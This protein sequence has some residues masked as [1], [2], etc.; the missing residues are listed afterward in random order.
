MHIHVYI[1][2]CIP[3]TQQSSKG[4]PSAR[5]SSSSVLPTSSSKP[6]IKKPLKE[7]IKSV[8]RR[9]RRLGK[10]SPMS[11]SSPSTS[12]DDDAFE[13]PPSVTP[14]PPKRRKISPP[15]V[16]VTRMKSEVGSSTSAAPLSAI[17]CTEEEESVAEERRTK[18]RRIPYTLV[19]ASKGNHCPTPGRNIGQ[20]EMHL[21]FLCMIHVHVCTCGKSV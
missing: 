6:R 3:L 8:K 11:D 18:R 17:G 20:L 7:P 15:V 9:S 12:S 10:Q 13:P 4:P 14:L 21:S 16:R 5:G 1:Y 19:E 2:T